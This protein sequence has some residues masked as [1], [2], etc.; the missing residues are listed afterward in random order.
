MKGNNMTIKKITAFF[1]ALSLLLGTSSAFAENETSDRYNVFEQV[2]GYISTY[3]IDESLTDQQIMNNAVSEY[4]KDDDEKLVG[5]LKSMLSA[6]DPYCEFF[7]AEEYRSF[8]NDLNRTF[9]GIGVRIEFID[10]YVMVAGFT[11]G[12]GAETAGIEVGDKISKVNGENMYGKNTT[13]VRNA[14]VGELGTEVEITVLRGNNEITYKVVRGEVNEDTVNYIKISDKVAYISVIDMS[15]NTPQEFKAALENADKDGI[16]NIILD[17]RNNGGGYLSCAVDMASLVVPKGVIVDTIYR[18]PFMNQT[19][20]SNLK[21]CKYNFNVLVNEY[22]ASAAEIF[23]SA[24]QDS[25]VGKII[26]VNTFGKGIIQSSFPLSNGSVFKLTVGHYVTRNGKEINGVGLTPDVEVKNE[27]VTINLSEYTPFTF[28]NKWHIGSADTNVYAA[29]EKLYY[30][31]YYEG[32]VNE[33]F[34]ETLKDAISLFQDDQ[35]LY[36]YGVLDITTQS[37]IDKEFSKIEIVNDDQLNKAYELFTG[38][39]QLPEEFR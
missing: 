6:L 35:D 12:S 18:Q 21:S 10:N 14:I 4:L 1:A 31:G 19:Y 16:K 26:G 2:A 36:P 3:Y 33:V 15:D 20:Y 34:D 28:K 38:E 11:S 27:A 39:K 8:V 9:Y 24:V 17:L 5:L 25:G 23:A 7:T 29:K 22:T 13:Y 37:R 30:L 32:A